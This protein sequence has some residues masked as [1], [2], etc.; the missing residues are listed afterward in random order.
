[1][2]LPAGEITDPLKTIASV[3]R[4][5]AKAAFNLA[6]EGAFFI[7]VG[8]DHSSGIGTWSGVANAL[9]PK[10]DIGLIWIDAHMDSHTQQTS[11]SG[12]IHGMPLAVLLGHGNDALTKIG[13]ASAKVKPENLVLIGIRS[14]EAGEEALLKALNVRIYFMEEVQMRGLSVVMKEALE[15]VTRNTV[16]FGV[17]FDLDSID[18]EFAPGVGT[19]VANGIHPD[20]MLSALCLLRDFPPLAFEFVEYIPSLDKNLKSFQFIQQL[21][22]TVVN[23]CQSSLKLA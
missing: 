12:N 13:D 7:S 17:S 23:I 8:G 16:G 6:K 22:K 21:L 14:F 11:E 18:P 9:R 5:L 2:I 1:M 3:N 20:E 15:I 10:G 4:Q 19:P